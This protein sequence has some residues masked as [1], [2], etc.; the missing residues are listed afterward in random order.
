VAARQ[1]L[2]R[3][4]ERQRELVVRR[5]LVE[6]HAADG[7]AGGGGVV[8][9][10]VALHDNPETVLRRLAAGLGI[11]EVR[12]TGMQLEHAFP[13][14]PPA[15]ERIR[16]RLGI[17]GDVRHLERVAERRAGVEAAARLVSGIPDDHAARRVLGVFEAQHVRDAGLEPLA[18]AEAHGNIAVGRIR[19]AGQR[20]G[21]A[22]EDLGAHM[23]DVGGEEQDFVAQLG[24]AKIHFVD[25][26]KGIDVERQTG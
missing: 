5:R 15:R 3:T 6:R 9:L 8:G 11:G 21:R 14:L 4:L 18:R 17:A 25:L 7:E 19:P 1:S 16:E 20:Q 2:R 22:A 13:D 10:T 24:G 26:A 12:V 23:G